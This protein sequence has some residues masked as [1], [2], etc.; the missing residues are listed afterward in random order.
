MIQR[1]PTIR[2]DSPAADARRALLASRLPA[3]PVLD[4]EGR[5]A[6]LLTDVQC[7]ALA[8][9]PTDERLAEHLRRDVPTVPPDAPVE[10][11][12]A[13]LLDHTTPAVAVVDGRDVVGLV[14]ARDLVRR[15][16]A[17]TNPAVNRLQVAFGVSVWTIA[18]VL[19]VVLSL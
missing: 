14:T 11:I 12:A 13:V 1:T 2:L 16:G 3:I 18:I 9:E 10:R 7:L 19:V 17:R 4:A 6:G 5:Y 15:L 8:I